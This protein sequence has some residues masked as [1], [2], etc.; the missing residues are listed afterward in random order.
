MPG[1]SKYS[2]GRKDAMTAIGNTEVE[3]DLKSNQGLSMACS[4]G[5]KDTKT[6]ENGL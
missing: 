6:T 2:G 1:G 3:S 5:M 4:G